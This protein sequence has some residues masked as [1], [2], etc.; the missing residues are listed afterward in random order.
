MAASF[1][2][3]EPTGL[4]AEGLWTVSALTSQLRAL[5][6]GEFGEVGLLGEISNLARPGSGHVY[7]RLKDDS[8]QIKAVLW[9][10]D[11][12][13][14]VFDLE[15]GLAV[16][17][18]GG[19]TV[20]EPRGEYQIVVRKIEPV[21][22]GPLELAFRQ[23]VAEA[24]GRGPLRPGSQ[25]ASCQGF[26]G[27]SSC[28][29]PDR[30]GGPRRDPRRPA[31]LAARGDPRGSLPGAGRGRRRGD[32]RGDRAG[33]SR[34]GGRPAHP[35]PGRRQ[36]GRPLGVQRGGR[37][38]GH[39]RLALAGRLGRRSRGGRDDR[40]PRGRPPGPDAQRRRRTLRARCPRGRRRA[41]GP[42]RPH[43]PRPAQPF[44]RRPRRASI[45][46]PTA[47]D[48]PCPPIST[49]VAATSPAWPPS[50][51]PSAPWLSSSR[52]YS[53]TQRLDDD[54]VVR[55][56]SDAPPGTRIRTRLASGAL[57]SRVQAIEPGADAK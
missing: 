22:I 9:R 52:G 36:P 51:T 45:P 32:R 21:G 19:L 16:R 14:L 33:Q 18:W 17:A 40:R 55:N 37:G 1:P 7:F 43:G 2:L 57:I 44:S 31:P 12:R 27:G 35:R 47:P 24:P 53:L 29:Q 5:L 26:P 15:D 8:A 25:A 56:P 13:R 50:S 30:R 10:S 41:R 48:V 28:R 38:A 20:Y 6:E 23:L 46:S 34:R 3:F 4:A 39:R 49:A 54:A 11:A 42:P